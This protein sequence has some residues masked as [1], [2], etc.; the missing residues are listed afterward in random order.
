MKRIAGILIIGLALFV[1]GCEDVSFDPFGDDDTTAA[2]A[3]PN[4]CTAQGC[5]QAS[6][7][8]QN[9]GYQS[10]TERFDRCLVSVNENLRKN[11][12]SM[13]APG[14]YPQ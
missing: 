6:Q 5:P 7:Y 3:Q 9:R 11:H 4:G 1:G 8:C 10:G 13:A 2:A 12:G 14:P